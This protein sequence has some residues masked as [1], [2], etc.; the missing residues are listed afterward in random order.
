MNRP[1]LVS[2]DGSSLVNGV[3]SDVQD[4]TKSSRADG[5]GNGSTSVRGLGATDET[6]GTCR[7]NEFFRS[8]LDD[9]DQGS[10]P[11]IA[12]QRTTFSPK[13]C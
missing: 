7:I 10:L 8:Y 1:E 11:S 2:L 5:D 6:L 3:T 9:D 4:T 13:C 12:M